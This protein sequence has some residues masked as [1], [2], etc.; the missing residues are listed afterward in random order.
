MALPERFDVT[1]T[2]EKGNEKRPIMLHRT[3]YGSLERFIGILTEHL[4]GKYPLWISPNQIK[5]M[6]MN[7]SVTP[8][9]KKIHDELFNVGFR[10]ELDDRNESIG[11]KVREA[12]IER[13][14][15]MITVGDKEMKEKKIAVKERDGK[16]VTEMSLDKFIEK[17]SEEVKGKK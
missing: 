12:S 11:K 10:V 2:D 5:V 7:D 1:Y 15:Y 14:N 17:L 13:F 6:T 8:Y 16:E 4:N 9:A 3:I